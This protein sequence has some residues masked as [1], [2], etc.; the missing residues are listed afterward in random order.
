MR[1]EIENAMDSLPFRRFNAYHGR[2]AGGGESLH[3]MQRILLIPGAVLEIDQSEIE[4]CRANHL[5]RERRSKRKKRANECLARRKP[6][7]QATRHI[8]NWIHLR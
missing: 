2:T 7:A 3:L 1:A 5:R 6:L 4:P 8:L